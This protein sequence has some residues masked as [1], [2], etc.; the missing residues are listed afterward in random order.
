[1][2]E[3]IAPAAVAGTI[4]GKVPVE[5]VNGNGCDEANKAGIVGPWGRE[6]KGSG[7]RMAMMRFRCAEVRMCAA[8]GRAVATM[9]RWCSSPVEI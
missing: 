7:I 8:E 6:A 1:M 9:R 5:L 4:A 2:D 3:G